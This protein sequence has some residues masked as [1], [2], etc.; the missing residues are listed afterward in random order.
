MLLK[1]VLQYTSNLYCNTPP[2]C[3]AV[4]SVPM[5]C[6]E[7]EVH[8]VLLPFVSQYASHSYR[9]TPPICIAILL[10][11]ILVVGVTRL[12][13]STVG[14]SRGQ[15]LAIFAKIGKFCY[16]LALISYQRSNF[17]QFLG[18]T[19]FSS[20]FLAPYWCLGFPIVGFDQLEISSKFPILL[21]EKL[22]SA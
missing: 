19:L 12:Q 7:R 10:R 20:T 13:K 21:A 18:S 4:L 8:S 17:W 5:S 9:N 2:I 14:G 15:K 3:L 11:K 1:K 6:D 16:S 22:A